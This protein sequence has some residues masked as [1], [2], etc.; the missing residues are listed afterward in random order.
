[1]PAIKLVAGMARSYKLTSPGSP[2]DKGA[3]GLGRLGGV[4]QPTRSTNPASSR[5]PT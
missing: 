4:T 1:M 5:N 2:P 3:G